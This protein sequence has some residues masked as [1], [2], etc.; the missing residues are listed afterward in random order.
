MN[1]GK[2]EIIK[3]I[4]LIIFMIVLIIFGCLA[5]KELFSFKNVDIKDVVISHIMEFDVGK[6]NYIETNYERYVAYKKLHSDYSD[7]M[8]ITY[9]NIGLDYEFYT[10]IVDTDMS[11]S[12]LVLCNKY[13]KL[14]SDYVPELVSLEGYG[15]G[16]MERVAAEYFKKMSDAAKKDGVK[17]YNVSGYRD[18]KLQAGLYE[19]YVDKDGKKKLIHIQQDQV[20][21]NIKQD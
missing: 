12:Y 11:D 4:V 10:N 21:Q 2:R 3:R 13:H 8:I 6:A 18:Y 7:E 19:K 14:K 20:H 5:Y 9:V 15:G 1:M 17:I 16:E